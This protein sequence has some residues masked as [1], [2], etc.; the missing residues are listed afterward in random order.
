MSNYCPYDT[1]SSTYDTCR[2]PLDLDDLLARIERLGSA[3][4]C[5][6]SDLRLLD[7]GAGSGNYFQSLRERGCMVQYHG[8]DFSQGML[9]QFR[10]KT[11]AKDEALRGVFALQQMNLKDLPLLLATASFDVVI[12]TQVLH[13]LSDGTD[14]HAPV[15]ALMGELARVIS[16]GGG[17]LWCQ[18]Q[19]Q[20][21]HADDGFWWSTITPQASRRLAD[22]FPPMDRFLESLTGCGE[23]KFGK[24]ESHVPNDP[25]MRVDMYLDVEGA[26]REEWRNCDSNWAICSEE[27]LEEGLRKLRGIIDAGKVEAFMAEREE[28]RARTG[29]TTTVVATKV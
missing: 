5:P 4:G 29:Q 11:M 28:A 7:V 17:F 27:E 13:H 18:T 25:L 19:T 10:E 2:R 26:F 9:D 3:R 15:Y 16:P 6:V 21:Q 14:D 24:V 8:L 20:A 23:H 22:R 1:T 12:V